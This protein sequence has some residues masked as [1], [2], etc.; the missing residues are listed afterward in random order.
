VQ[1][2]LIEM[3]DG[4]REPQTDELAAARARIARLEALF[5]AMGIT[6]CALSYALDSASPIDALRAAGVLTL[7]RA[8]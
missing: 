8:S 5:E 3:A 1:Q 2:S 4:R 7:Q 6:S